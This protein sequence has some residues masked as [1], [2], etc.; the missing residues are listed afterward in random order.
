MSKKDI[1]HTIADYLSDYIWESLSTI[2]PIGYLFI[3]IYY[4]TMSNICLVLCIIASILL[5][6]CCSIFLIKKNK[7]ITSFE[8]EI[9]DKSA[10]IQEY[11]S[12]IEK[13]G[14][15]SYDLFRYSIS[16]LFKDFKL[17]DRSRIS[18]YKKS[19]NRFV[20]M[21]RFSTNPELDRINRK[22]YPLEEGF[23]GKAYREGV[24]FIDNLPVFKEGVKQKYYDAVTKLC[25][26]NKDVLKTISMKSRTYYCKA[27]TD[28]RAVD[29]KAV[30]VIESLDEKKFSKDNI[31][32]ALGEEEERLKYFIENFKFGIPESC[33]EKA[34]KEGF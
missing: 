16:L 25:D 33:I 28:F 18:V 9:N 21:G 1:F 4:N 22:D 12:T 29:R 6:I 7:S 19:N 2:P 30:I 3:S 32:K 34:K 27:L 26:I 8:K 17:D 10:K 31:Q 11:E 15:E 23:I 14:N 5:S 20:I 13:Y 24:F